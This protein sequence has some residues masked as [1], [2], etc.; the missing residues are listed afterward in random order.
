MARTA[1]RRL[2]SKGRPTSLKL[3]GASRIS[4]VKS[5]WPKQIVKRDGRIVPFDKE[6]ITIAVS[7]AMNEAGELR[8]GAPELVRDGVM[9][10]LL[11]LHKLSRNFVPTVEQIQDLVEKQLILNK[12]AAAAKG[13]ILYRQKHAEMRAAAREV[14]E[15]VRELAAESAAYFSN[16]LSELVYYTTYSKW[17]PEENR[18]ET[19]IETVDRYMNF[20]RENL[21]DKLREDEYVE[22]R[23]SMLRMRS[24]GSM[25]L[26]WSAGSAARKS[27]VCAYNCSYVAPSS[28][29]DFGEIMYISMCGTGLG[30]S[31]EQQTVGLL[32]MIERQT[33]K[34]VPTYVIKDS[35]EGWA[36]SLVHGME[37]WSKGLGVE[38]D[39]S[40]IR[41]AGARLVTMGGRASGP[42]PLRRLL[43]FTRERMLSR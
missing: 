37:T 28:W 12:F 20:M 7:K 26:F 43:A 6:R 16:K 36:D 19:W 22:I 30:F 23:D 29:Q 8:E 11:H 5:V 34:K 17:V 40:Q 2:S 42:D 15:K 33:G 14:P 35:K 25:R 13:Y 21:G 38:F 27:N 41:P 18:R 4:T 10:E 9:A 1:M 24:M 32:P 39:F 3:R 31:V